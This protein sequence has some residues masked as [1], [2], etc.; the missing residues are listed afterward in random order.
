MSNNIFNIDFYEFLELLE[1]YKVDFLLVGGYAV[2]LHGFVRSTGDID[3]W[4]ERTEVNYTKLEKVYQD[5]TAP[6]FPKEQFF[7]ENITV[8]GIGVEP[9]KIELITKVDGLQFQ[10]SFAK[11]AYFKVEKLNVPYIDFED[12]IKNKLASGRYKDLA[13]VEQ[14]Q[15]NKK[16][17]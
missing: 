2:V 15:K 5:F 7:D 8:W 17:I 1:K 14:L 11:C 6:I 10:E 13:D 4:I 9:T 12:L 16:N 3:L